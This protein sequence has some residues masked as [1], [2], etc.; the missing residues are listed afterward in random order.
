MDPLKVKIKQLPEMIWVQPIVG[1][2]IPVR[3]DE[4]GV[5]STVCMMSK[6]LGM[7]CTLIR[8]KDEQ[9]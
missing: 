5:D 1:K 2:A 4:S 7:P 3:V 8:R 9:G 6:Q